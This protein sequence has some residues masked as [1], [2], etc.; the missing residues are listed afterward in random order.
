MNDELERIRKEAV[1]AVLNLLSWH[2]LG[3]TEDYYE[4]QRQDSQP[5]DRDFNPEASSRN[6][7]ANSRLRR[8]L[9][10][11]NAVVNNTLVKYVY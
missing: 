8:S 7:D 4:D 9:P 1:V 6:Q 3:E 11:L 10:L 2:F 5:P